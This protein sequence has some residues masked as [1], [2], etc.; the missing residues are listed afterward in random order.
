MATIIPYSGLLRV[1][2]KRELAHLSVLFPSLFFT[3]QE[4]VDRF[5]SLSLNAALLFC[6]VDD[7]QS[8]LLFQGSVESV[9]NPGPGP[10]D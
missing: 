3:I 7:I 2:K 4:L 5:Y 10:A 6:L 1:T 8:E 9:Y